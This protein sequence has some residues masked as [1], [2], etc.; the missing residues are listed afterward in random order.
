MSADGFRPDLITVTAKAISEINE[1]LKGQGYEDEDLTAPPLRL[2]CALPDFSMEARC[3]W[4]HK[5]VTCSQRMSFSNLDAPTILRVYQQACDSWNAVCG[6]RL[7]YT[8][9]FDVANIY[10]RS[11][12]IDGAGGTLAWS[13]LPC[14]A[15]RTSRM[16]Q[17]YDDREKWSVALLLNTVMHEIGH[18][19]GLPHGPKNSVMYAYAN[20]GVITLQTWDKDEAVARYGPA[21]AV[22]VPIPPIVPV[23][24]PPVVPGAAVGFGAFEIG[25]V[26]YKQTIER[27]A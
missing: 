7:T 20:A 26:V 19:I 16:E 9:D 18:A 25:G 6:L 4:P 3:A 2:R 15:T 17:L 21:T 10:S 27:A 1:I 8:M 14:G 23:P 5:D 22:P 11:G 24:L 12:K 13:Y